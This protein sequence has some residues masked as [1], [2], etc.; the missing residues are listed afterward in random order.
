ME[1]QIFQLRLSGELIKFSCDSHQRWWYAYETYATLIG[2]QKRKG[3][4]RS[5]ALIVVK[6]F[7]Q[8]DDK[9]KKTDDGKKKKWNNI[10]KIIK[11]RKTYESEE[12]C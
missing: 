7:R 6:D 5:W 9:P 11:K 10:L 2:K 1:D 12:D 3:K 4:T 8:F